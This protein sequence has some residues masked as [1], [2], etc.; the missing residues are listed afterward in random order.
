VQR[1][2]KKAIPHERKNDFVQRAI[3]AVRDV[4]GIDDG[5]VSG[6]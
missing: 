3:G 6:W 4:V 2:A 1:S 5:V